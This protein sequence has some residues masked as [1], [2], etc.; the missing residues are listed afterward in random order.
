MSATNFFFIC[1]LFHQN[2][3]FYLAKWVDLYFDL[4][5][6]FPFSFGCIMTSFKLE[7]KYL[8]LWGRFSFIFILCSLWKCSELL[9]VSADQ[10][11]FPMVK[12]I[13]AYLYVTQLINYYIFFFYIEMVQFISFL[14]GVY[15]CW[16]IWRNDMYTLMHTYIHTSSN[17]FFSTLVNV[18][19][20]RY[21]VGLNLELHGCK[22]CLS[23][24]QM[25]KKK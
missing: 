18:I 1:A 24:I 21:T 13:K 14:N 6:I 16:Y 5:N 11:L 4:I 9:I 15:I 3:Y 17:V 20:Q 22:S 19:Y 10:S 23:Y 25:P 12:M 7:L 2:A 8:L